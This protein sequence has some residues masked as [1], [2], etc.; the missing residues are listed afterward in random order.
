MLPC[1]STCSMGTILSLFQANFVWTFRLHLDTFY[2]LHS[3]ICSLNQILCE[4]SQS[5]SVCNFCTLVSLRLTPSSKYSAEHCVLLSREFENS[6]TLSRSSA[7]TLC[8]INPI[9]HSQATTNIFVHLTALIARLFAPFLPS[10]PEFK[11]WDK[12][13][14][15]ISHFSHVCL[16][17]HHF[18]SPSSDHVCS[19][20]RHN[21]YSFLRPC[22]TY[23]CVIISYWRQHSAFTYTPI[24]F[25][26]YSNR[27]KHFI[28][29]QHLQCLWFINTFLVSRQKVKNS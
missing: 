29:K 9:H 20:L 22:V 16:V 25:Y 28:R 2:I 1:T 17:P 18:L 4:N 12:S 14:V 3:S 24:K 21:I 15:P 23:A 5:T 7:D 19:A 13:F 27:V 8:R 10:V 11:V 26:S 6:L